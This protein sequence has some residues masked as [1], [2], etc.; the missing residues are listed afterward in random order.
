MTKEERI[1]KLRAAYE[2]FGGQWKD[3]ET[4]ANALNEQ[5]ITQARGGAWTPGNVWQQL[6]KHCPDLVEGRTREKG[7]KSKKE[8]KSPPKP[9]NRE[10]KPKKTTSEVKEL[11]PLPLSRPTFKKGPRE[12]QGSFR[13]RQDMYER[14]VKKLEKDR[15]RTGGTV[16][17]LVEVLFWMYIGAPED[18]LEENPYA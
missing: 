11:I 7:K 2:E 10:E 6:V 4:I 17:S 8:A 1:S 16:S 9:R 14:V 12:K 15:V 5:G 18:V 13:V 3:T